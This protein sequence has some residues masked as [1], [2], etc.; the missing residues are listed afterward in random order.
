LGS[1]EEMRRSNRGIPGGEPLIHPEMAKI[2]KAL[3]R[4][5][6]TSIYAP[7]PSCSNGS[8]MSTRLKFLT[9]SIHMDGLKD[10]HDLAVCRDG[11]YDVAV[12]AIKA[13]LAARHQS[14]QTPPCSMMQSERVR[15]F[16]DEMMALGRRHDDFS[17]TATKSARPAAFSQAVRTKSCFPR[18]SPVRRAWQFNQSPLFLDFLMGR[19]SITALRGK[20]TYNVFGYG[21]VISCRKA[22]QGFRDL[23]DTTA[24]QDYGST[25]NEMRH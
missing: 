23:M 18:F 21:P 11:V 6:G 2:V 24:W 17:R 9:F 4:K 5:N 3:L 1:G 20:P 8:S 25:K 10:E 13:A 14:R 7:T 19:R 16:F 22:M 15:K 12:R